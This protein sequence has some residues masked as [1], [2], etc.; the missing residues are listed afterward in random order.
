MAIEDIKHKEL[1]QSERDVLKADRE[2]WRRMGSSAHLQDWLDYY[3]GLDIRRR[4]AQRLAFTNRPAGKG[5]VLAYSQL[6]RDDGFDT[7]DKTLMSQMSAV[8]WLRDDPE[9]EKILREILAALTPGQRSRLNTPIAARQRVMALLKAR[10]GGSE[11]KFKQSPVRIYKEQIAEQNREIAHLKEQLA[12]AENETS[13]FDLKR[14]SAGQIIRVFTDPT[15]ISEGKATTI[16]RGVLAAFK[17]R[18][19]PA[20]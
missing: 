3:P 4:L 6:M 18:K 12:A 13:L 17:A 10:E 2:R 9:R 15:A 20:G 14:D 11:D 5:Y 19:K 1:T 7:D 8:L 16:A